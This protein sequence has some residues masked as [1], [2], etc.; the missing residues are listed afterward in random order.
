[1]FEGNQDP[2]GEDTQASKG[3][4]NQA[5]KGGVGEVPEGEGSE[6]FEDALNV[7]LDENDGIESS[8]GSFYVSFHIIRMKLLV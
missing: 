5:S 2:K 3:E 4:D 7:G 6:A 1:M 8:D